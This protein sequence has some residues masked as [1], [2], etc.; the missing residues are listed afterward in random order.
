[1]DGGRDF[2]SSLV[3]RSSAPL[4]SSAILDLLSSQLRQSK[5]RSAVA[6]FIS[7]TRRSRAALSPSHHASQKR[8]EETASKEPFQEN[9]ADLHVSLNPRFGTWQRHRLNNAE[10]RATK[11]HKA[12][13]LPT[14]QL[15]IE[16]TQ[17]VVVIYDLLKTTLCL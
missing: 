5:L 17:K 11:L 2:P 6:A 7:L 9:C 15:K 14:Q 8:K 10:S 1:M 13:Q 3:A 4:R 16:A 12:R